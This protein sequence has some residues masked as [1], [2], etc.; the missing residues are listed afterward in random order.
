MTAPQHTF[1]GTIATD[2]RDSVPDWSA[3]RPAPPPAGSPNVLYLLWDDTGIATWDCFGGLVQMPTMRRIAERGV[4]LTQFHTTALCSPTRAALLTGRNATTVGVSSVVNLAQ[5]YPGQN[6]RIP[7]ETAMASEVLSQHGWAT[8]AVGKW[9]LAPPE[10]CHAAGA[11]T[12]W[13]LA[14]GFDR[15][16]G[17]LDG[18][19][20]QWYPSLVR[21]NTPIDPPATPQQGYHLSKDLADNAIGFLREHRAAAPDKPWF[22]YFCP[23]AGHSPHQV[24]PHWADHYRGT[25]D[26]GY[27]KYREIV[28]S[29]QKALGVLPPDTALSP[30]NPY[31]DCT[32]VDGLAWPEQE[33]VLPWD[34]LTDD[35]KRVSIRMAEVFAGFLSYTDAQIGRLVDHLEQTG[36]LDNTVIVIMSDNG[37]SGEGGPNGTLADL[38]FVGGDSS[39]EAMLAK[40]DTFGGPGT[41][42]NYSNG[43][44]MA[45]NTPYKMYK[46]YA[47]HEG[48]IADPCIV[49][50]PAGLP[51]RGEVRDHYVHVSDI[52]PTLYDLIGITAP[53]EVR[54][55]PQKPLEGSSFAAALHD[56][57]SPREKHTQ[58]YSMLGTRGIWHDGWFANTVH[59]PTSTG[60]KGWSNFDADR[61]ELFHIDSDRS[62]LHDLAQ[63]HPE[64]LAELRAL[65]HEQALAFN[66]Y[67]LNDLGL[68]ELFLS[69]AVGAAG[70]SA[71][72]IYY[73][74]VPAAHTPIGG[75]IRG[76]SFT[77][78]T[79]LQVQATGANGVLF[80][81]GDGSVGQVIYLTDGR[82]HYVVN[83]WGEEQLVATVAP[84]PPGRHHITLTFTRQG[85]IPGTLDTT[86]EVTIIVDGDV[87]TAT[88][89]VGFPGLD[90]RQAITVGRSVVH[91]V[92]AAYTSPATLTGAT[93][94]E[95][96]IEVIGDGTDVGGVVRE[97]LFERD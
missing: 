6:G 93:V 83:R 3:Y 67:P 90:P 35:Q 56:P 50:W 57:S 1:G 13:P 81:Q 84:L 26:M 63:T 18:M 14:R 49:S 91:P 62:Q 38:R 33:N 58:F 52:T 89:G 32:S 97:V 11:R 29:N 7:A 19:T 72:T 73:P 60:P 61:W 4:L 55:I 16:Y 66:G 53:V 70:S 5:G 2:I 74:N 25:F 47:S 77:V 30:M 36:Q 20:D 54:G 31:A 76:R 92:S 65:W 45:F 46:R 85:A 48:G 42:M 78:Q 69:G 86:G 34:S 12:Y 23:G 39:T 43:W 37:A 64:R 71:Q 88:A 27:E 28:L 44:A 96:R 17:F 21:D 40:I 51:A 8:Y 75:L 68:V 80:S 10:D 94:D 95:V 79:T 24:D 41:S 15:F 82:L 9:H 22:M 59:P 87:V